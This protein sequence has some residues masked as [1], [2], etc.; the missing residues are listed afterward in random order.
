MPFVCYSKL[1]CFLSY[2]R[3]PLSL[4]RAVAEEMQVQAE[5]LLTAGMVL[6]TTDPSVLVLVEVQV[7]ANDTPV[8]VVWEVQEG[9]LFT[10]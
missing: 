7:N 4:A 5:L 9:Q 6:Y 2:R 1:Q 8:Q 3:Y 10:G